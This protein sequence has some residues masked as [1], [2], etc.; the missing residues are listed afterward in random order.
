[1]KSQLQQYEEFVQVI[2]DPVMRHHVLTEQED[3]HYK[4]FLQSVLGKDKFVMTHPT[5]YHAIS[6][7][8]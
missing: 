4:L 8:I 3:H 6:K 5:V 2:N 7:N 1:M